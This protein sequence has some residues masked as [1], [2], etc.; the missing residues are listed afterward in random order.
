MIRLHNRHVSSASSSIRFRWCVSC[1]MVTFVCVSCGSAP[2]AVRAP[3]AAI[4]SKTVAP[5][6]DVA[7]DATDFDL[8]V[9]LV[10]GSEIIDLGPQH[11]GRQVLSAKGAKI[12]GIGQIWSPFGAGQTVARTPDGGI[13]VMARPADADPLDVAA[14]QVVLV[15]K[16]GSTTVLAS[17]VTSM[18]VNSKGDVAISRIVDDSGLMTVVEVVD[19]TS[20]KVTPWIDVPDR[21]LVSLW[22][23]DRLLVNQSPGAEAPYN[24]LQIDAPGKLQTL[25]APGGLVGVSPNGETAVIV[26]SGPNGEA[27]TTSVVNLDTSHELIVEVPGLASGAAWN[28]DTLA[29]SAFGEKGPMLLLYAISDEAIRL[30]KRIAFEQTMTP[31]LLQPFID[32]KVFGALGTNGVI[33][34]DPRTHAVSGNPGLLVTCPI[35][36]DSQ[37]CAYTE[38]GASTQLILIPR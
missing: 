7:P 28:G 24:L 9:L 36:G 18:A 26:R 14:A 20:R 5:A 25:A 1:T 30:V 13:V 23:N 34:P 12:P 6:P 3:Q 29:M 10:A 16:D 17:R 11:S 33:M 31:T 2:Q 8:P 19:P 35:E 22:A 37:S 21:Y 38:I 4:P 32:G 27:L 15:S